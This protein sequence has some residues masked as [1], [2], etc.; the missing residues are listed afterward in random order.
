MNKKPA[1]SSARK[2]PAAL[3]IFQGMI[4]MALTIWAVRD[5]RQRRDDELSKSRKVWMLAAFAPPF[6]PM[7]YFVFG[8]KRDV[9]AVEVQPVMANEVQHV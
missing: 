2:T 9:Q 4:N 5:I 6:G 7:A 1:N 8:R 3:R